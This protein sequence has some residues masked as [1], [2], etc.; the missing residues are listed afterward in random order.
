MKIGISGIFLK[1]PASG[2]G[3]LLIHLLKALE[4]IDHR[5]EYILLGAQSTP[6]RN[7]AGTRFPI[8]TAPVPAYAARKENTEQVM[9]EQFTG[10]AAARKAGVDLFHIPYYAPPLILRSPTI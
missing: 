2:L 9:W 1:Y 6:W 5:N 3:Q 7:V 4:E 10:P 8:Q